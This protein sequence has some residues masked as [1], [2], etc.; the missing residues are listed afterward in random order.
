[1]SELPLW[2]SENSPCL[3]KP[4]ARRADK[5]R[6]HRPLIQKKG[7]HAVGHKKLILDIIMG[8]AIPLATLKWGTDIIGA[9][10]SFII[11]GL[12][13]AIY[14]LCDVLF[15]TKRFNAITTI[16]AIT[17]TTQ[18]G[19]AFL[20]VDGWKYA[21]QDTAGTIVMFTLFTATL[22]LGKP[23]VQ[24]FAVQV[25]EPA[26]PKEEATIWRLIT[27][28]GPVRKA[29]ILGTLLIMAE[30]LVRG[31][32]NYYL[33]LY[34]VTAEFG[35]KEFNDQKAAVTAIAWLPFTVTNLGAM[36]FAVGMVIRAV[37]SWV[38]DAGD[39]G[40]TL[41]EQIERRFQALEPTAPTTPATATKPATGEA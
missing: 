18:G 8:A 35:S 2:V 33:N 38:E 17:A 30:Q 1:M 14:V 5:P 4:L 36:V 6:P 25:L 20:K 7:L 31:F 15:I 3:A 28:P 19:L 22:L 24:Y 41:A 12:V 16:I 21:L 32:A 40:G 27:R 34:R 37:D 23:M 11:A 10:P 9:R 13:P 26:N 39:E 29:I